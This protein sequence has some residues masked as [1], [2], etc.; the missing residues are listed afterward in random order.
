MKMTNKKQYT[1]P[2]AEMLVFFTAEDIAELPLSENVGLSQPFYGEEV[3][4][5]V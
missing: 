1:K 4:F 3:P 2:E 5:E